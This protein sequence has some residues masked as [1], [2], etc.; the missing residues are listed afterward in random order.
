MRNPRLRRRLAAAATAVVAALAVSITGTPAAHACAALSG[1]GSSAHPWVIESSAQMSDLW[2]CTYFADSFVLTADVTVTNSAVFMWP[3]TGTFDGQGHTVTFDGVVNAPGLFQET[4][5][6]TVSNVSI[7]AINGSTLATAAG[8]ISSMD[9]GST[10]TNIHTSGAIPESGGGVVGPARGTHLTDVVSSGSVGDFGGGIVGRYSLGVI[11]DGA[12]SSGA[13]GLCAGGIIGASANDG[14]S[15]EATTVTRSYSTG[16]LGMGAGGIV[17]AFANNGAQSATITVTRS[18]STG[19]IGVSG[20]GIVG[21]QSNNAAVSSAV[22]VTNS[23][24]TGSIGAQGGG[25]VGFGVNYAAVGSTMALDQVF[26]SGSIDVTAGGVVGLSANYSAESAQMTVS[27]A[28]STGVIGAYAG[29]ILGSFANINA[30]GAS[31]NVSSVYSTGAIDVTGGGIIG[32]DAR[33]VSVNH[34]YTAGASAGVGNGV[35]G[36]NSTAVNE[37]D[38]YAESAHGG[39]GFIDANFASVVAAV[40]PWTQGDWGSCQPNTPPFL[41]SIYTRNPCVSAPTRFPAAAASF[42]AGEGEYALSASALV[43]G[44]RRHFYAVNL[45]HG[46]PGGFLEVYAEPGVASSAGQACVEADPCLVPNGSYIDG[47]TQRSF[48]AGHT[49]SVHVRYL[50]A[51][52][53]SAEDVGTLDLIA[54]FTL[55]GKRS[56]R[57]VTFQGRSSSHLPTSRLT[58]MTKVAGAATFSASGSVSN[59]TGRYEWTRTLRTGKSIEAYVT[60]GAAQSPHVTI[61]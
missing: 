61:S 17:G 5:H 25:I 57:T 38:T 54:N 51:R 56:G 21:T 33:D 35:I 59:D 16:S 42:D 32:S 52:Y 15:A 39:S 26:S 46:M 37:N 12:S 22:T 49:G 41:Q 13:I 30:V 36:P 29:G 14:G 24:S 10:F 20:G 11:V 7:D 9:V 3:F 8:W 19:T 31:V 6:A 58:I 4:D 40:S 45:V 44:H 55:S 34:G 2:T 1:D 50:A 23:F 27:R 48:T 47:G 18:F 60:D 43:P 28:Y 53:A